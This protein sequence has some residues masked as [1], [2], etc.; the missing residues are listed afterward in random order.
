[1][2]NKIFLKENGETKEF[3]IDYTPFN[4]EKDLK[5]NHLCPKCDNCYAAKCSKVLDDVKMPIDSYD[6][7]SDGIQ[8][9]DN[10][11]EMKTFYVTKC[12]NYV[13]DH[14]RNKATTREEIE[15]L[16]KLKESIKILFFNAENIEEADQI[17]YDLL[18]RRQIRFPEPYNRKK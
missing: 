18:M 13:K 11:D 5:L 10:N 14:V 4:N 15:R 1:M 2:K 8:V 6:F 16:N 9:Y 7:I 12:D 3:R 17:Q